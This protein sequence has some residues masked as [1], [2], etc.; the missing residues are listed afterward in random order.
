MGGREVELLG[1]RID[2]PGTNGVADVFHS[3]AMVLPSQVRGCGPF[4][5]GFG[6]WINRPEDPAERAAAIA[7]YAALMADASLDLIGARDL[8]LVEGRFASSEVFVR[9]LGALRPDMRIVTSKVEA[10][11]SFGALRL[12]LPDLAPPGE[13]T[14]VEPLGGNLAAYREQWLDD[15]ESFA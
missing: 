11:A 12:V 1:E 7:L 2:L 5:H 13:L 14:T 4:P 9:A 3:E 15:I 8:L 10:D 6:R